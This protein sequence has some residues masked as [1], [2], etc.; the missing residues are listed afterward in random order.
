[1]TTVSPFRSPLIAAI[2]PRQRYAAL[3]S[4]T[5]EGM[6]HRKRIRS[7]SSRDR[8]APLCALLTRGSRSAAAAAVGAL[9][10]GSGIGGTLLP[11]RRCSPQS[12]LHATTHTLLD[13]TGVQGCPSLF[14]Y[15]CRLYTCRQEIAAVSQQF[16]GQSRRNA[17]LVNTG[18]GFGMS[19]ADRNDLK[20]TEYVHTTAVQ[21]LASDVIGF[22][23]ALCVKRR[24]CSYCC[25]AYASGI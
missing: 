9:L 6:A 25:C 12:S 13:S 5:G 2:V 8:R 24:S 20:I 18:D 7:S 21:R 22:G 14:L 10:P 19:P 17:Y 15:T 1:M 3:P 23:V 4:L 16:A 11:V